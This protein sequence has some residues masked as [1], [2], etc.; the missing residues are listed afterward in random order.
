MYVGVSVCVRVLQT[1]SQALTC[2]LLAQPQM[3]VPWQTSTW[4]QSSLALPW[5]TSFIRYPVPHFFFAEKGVLIY[6]S[7]TLACRNLE[8]PICFI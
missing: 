1:Q 8:G 5:T 6:N 3:C 4:R 2:E 7:P